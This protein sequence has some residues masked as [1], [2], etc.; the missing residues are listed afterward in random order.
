[1][2]E[3]P[4]RP[5]LGVVAISYNEERDL[6]GF[7]RNL[8]PWVDEI[9][10]VD[11][12]STDATKELAEAAGEKVNFVVSKRV[13]GEYYADQRNKGIAAAKSD[14][15]LH[16]DIDERVTPAFAKEVRTAIANPDYDGYRFARINYFLH[17]PMRGG[18]W[19][20]WN[21]IHL[22]RR[23]R[24]RFAGMFHESCLLDAPESRTGQ[25][26]E[27]ML[28][29]NDENYRERMRKSDNYLPELMERIRERGKP[30]GSLSLIKA[31]CRDFVY[32]Y[33]YKRGYRD[34]AQG[35]LFAMHAGCA[36]FRAHALVWDEQNTLSRQELED[37]L[38]EIPP[39]P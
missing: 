26:R 39:M 33:F 32:K 35:V 37:S 18:G 36:S 14:W 22:A 24:F 4:T 20:D 16:M 2:T 8:L 3:T 34:G 23:E 1:M 21:Q 10:I 27:K 31:F 7:L 30:V 11:D 19:Q 28:H 15:L 5:T 17:R 25:L 29:L 12:G 6:P 9:V 13:E 38:E